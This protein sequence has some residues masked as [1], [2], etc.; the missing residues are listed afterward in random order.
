MYRNWQRFQDDLNPA[1][2]EKRGK[3][4]STV[5]PIHSDIQKLKRIAYYI[6]LGMT[7]IKPKWPFGGIYV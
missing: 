5:A 3:P 2:P 1:D 7:A 6:V 4:E